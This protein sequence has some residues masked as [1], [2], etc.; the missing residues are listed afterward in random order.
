MVAV[1][2]PK[3]YSLLLG[4]QP[5]RMFDLDKKNT[6]MIQQSQLYFSRYFEERVTFGDIADG[7]D[8]LYNEYDDL[9][10]KDQVFKDEKSRGENA[11]VPSTKEEEDVAK[12]VAEDVA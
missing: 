1:H 12:D 4:V 6:Q 5:N 11:G 3:K 10:N 7:I 8:C 2:L 9:I